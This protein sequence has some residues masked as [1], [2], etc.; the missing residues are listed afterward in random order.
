MVIYPAIFHEDEGSYWVEF[1]D[2]K[3]CLTDGETPEKAFVMAQEALGLYL[4]SLLERG[5]TLPKASDITA[6]KSD[7]GIVNMVPCDLPKYSRSQ[8][9]VKK[10]LTIP[11][12]LNAE[13]ERRH[14][15]FSK[16]L[17]DALIAQIGA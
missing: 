11:E 7:D 12:W 8:K 10:T 6:L 5:L 1:P 9:A 17:Q 3:G 4:N 16:A 13:A 15:N 14:V 2:L